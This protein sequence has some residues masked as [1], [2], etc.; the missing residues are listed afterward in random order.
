MSRVIK[1]AIYDDEP[2]FVA[3]P[4]KVVSSDED[5]TQTDEELMTPEAQEHMLA[6]IRR[7][8]E[9]A[10]QLLK[11]A[12]VQA[13]IIRQEAKAATEKL[14]LDTQNQVEAIQE[15]ARKKGY[16]QGLADGRETGAKQIREEQHQIL[17]DANAGAERV[18]KEAQDACQEY[19]T[20]AENTIAEMVLKIANKVLPQHFIDVPQII[21]P[22]VQEAVRKVKDQPKVVVKVAPESYELVM[23]AQSE[24]QSQLE[25]SGILEIESDASLKTG[26]CLVESPNGVVDA[27]VTTQLELIEQAVRNVMK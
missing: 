13:E 2:K 26:D 17:V 9:K 6:E 1:G 10:S 25:G 14:M 27:G 7:K 24:L 12:Q 3:V 19:V 16:E 20:S 15:E 5:G 18:L 11:D 21:L 23:M 4:T 22:L 8:E